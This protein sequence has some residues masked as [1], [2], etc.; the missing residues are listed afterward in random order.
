MV[1]HRGRHQQTTYL[2]LPSPN[3]KNSCTIFDEALHEDLDECQVNNP[4]ITLLQHKDDLLITPESR[5]SCQKETQRLLQTL[6]DMGYPASAKKAQL[7]KTEVPYLSYILKEGQPWLSAARK[8]AVL[9][10]PTSSTPQQ[11]RE[12]LGST[13]FCRLWIPGFAKMAWPLRN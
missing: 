6:G 3:F 4:D 11:V 9:S 7:C 2:D 5:E 13:D 10:I 8:E 12:F 1:Q